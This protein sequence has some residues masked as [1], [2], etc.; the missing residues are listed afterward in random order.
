MLLHLK[1]LQKNTKQYLGMLDEMGEMWVWQLADSTCQVAYNFTDSLYNPGNFSMKHCL[2]WNYNKIWGLMKY[3]VRRN[4]W[5]SKQ[6][7][8][9]V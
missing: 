4:S 7:V 1:I 3:L 9:A 8:V 6:K 2:V 5:S